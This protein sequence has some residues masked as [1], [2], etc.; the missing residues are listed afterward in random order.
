MSNVQSLWKKKSNKLDKSFVPVAF[1]NKVAPTIDLTDD[2]V[3]QC[4]RD[5]PVEKNTFI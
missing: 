3:A 1:S 4:E 5:V 2:L